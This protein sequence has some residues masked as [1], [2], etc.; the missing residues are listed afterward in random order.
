M[1]NFRQL[2]P[3]L[4]LKPPAAFLSLQKD[5]TQRPGQGL[6]LLAWVLTN[7][8]Q[9]QQHILDLGKGAVHGIS[10]N[11]HTAQLAGGCTKTGGARYYPKFGVHSAELD[12]TRS[13]CQGGTHWGRKSSF[14]PSPQLKEV[15]SKAK[16]KEAQQDPS[17]H[18]RVPLCTQ[19]CSCSEWGWYSQCP[20]L[21]P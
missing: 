21:H 10:L 9:Q 7:G 6:L 15:K 19:D 20:P 5:K 11:S 12:Q 4:T 8:V 3:Y 14:V 2:Q 1:P 18:P 17:M 13:C 16:E